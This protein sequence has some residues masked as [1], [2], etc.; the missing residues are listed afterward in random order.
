M[1]F[2]TALA[3]AVAFLVVAPYFAH[4]LRRRRAEER[5]FAA[6]H[7]V[8]PAPPQARRRSELED[9]ALFAV[10]ALA[11]LAL[12][13]LGASPLVR[14]SRLSLDR[15][16]G[17]SV[18]MAIVIDDSMS[19]R[20]GAGR[21][22]RFARA[23]AGADELLGSAREGDAVAIVLAGASARVALAAT[24]DLGAARAAL[25][26]VTASD[27][28][29]DLEGA[30]ALAGGLLGQMP[31]VD[32]R[33]VLLSDL[34][35]GRAD[36]P[37][38]GK[39]SAIPIWVPLPE[40]L[41]PQAD[42]AILTADRIG[43]RVRVEVEC[44]PDAKL[45]GRE[46]VLE[47]DD[48]AVTRAAIPEGARSVTLTV[49]A[50]E[51][52]PLVAHLT[53]DDA[54][55][56]NDFAP[57]VFE[58]GPFA[59]AVV[60]DVASESAATGGAPVVEQALSALKLDVAVRPLPAFPDRVEDLEPFVGVILDD[61]PGLTPEQRRAVLAFLERGGVLLLAL[62]PRAAAAPLGA[63]LEP[64][65]KSAVAFRPTSA[66]GADP[67]S[68]TLFFADSAASL[69]DLDARMRASL[70]PEDLRSLDVLLRWDDGEP[71]VGTKPV[72]RGEAWVVTLPF[73]VDTSDVTLRPGF[74]ALLDAWVSEARAR[75]APRRTEVGTPWTFP[76]AKQVAVTG[77]DG[78]VAVA[79]DVTPIRVVP[80]VLGRYAIDIDGRK[81]LRVAAPVARELDFR[82]RQVSEKAVSVQSE[83]TRASVDVSWMIALALLALVLV[84]MALRARAAGRAAAVAG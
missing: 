34:A 57:V 15:A 49:A 80:S 65:L 67:A 39:D 71:L 42:C 22:T 19:M 78:P 14:C 45:T 5:P 51:E 76:G 44:S 16:G 17:A 11:V 83:A 50:T 33:I 29:T 23:K 64:V 58:A 56:H 9:R 32:R 47:S 21:A 62:G 77:P 36:G 69:E 31:Q 4:R 35:D 81:E 54:I 28:A 75:A 25:E 3:L 43:Q 84:E 79:S 41:A 2:V 38:L 63:T 60:G 46:V 59:L 72:S 70:G 20:A 82:P 52:R 73:A 53:G 30:L 37:A 7:L 10:R 8:K 27:R 68:A 24:T 13:L 61:P 66:R 18:A 1:R 12:A 40:L 26:A 55:A 48:V 6:A 74:L